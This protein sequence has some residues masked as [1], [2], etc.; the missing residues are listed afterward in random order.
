MVRRVKGKGKVLFEVIY[1]HRR[2]RACQVAGCQVWIIEVEASDEDLFVFMDRENRSRKNPSAFELGDS[3]RRALEARLFPSLNVLSQKL[4][5]DLGNASKA[6]KIATL[7]ADVLAA[8]PRLTEI[9]YRWSKPLSDALQSDP[10]AV[11]A[12]ARRIT[13]E[14]R[15]LSAAQV[16]EQLIG[17]LKGTPTSLE[18]RKAGVD[19]PVALI[20]RADNGSVT[21]KISAGCVAP[22]RLANLQKLI[23][24]FLATKP[25]RMRSGAGG[26]YRTTPFFFVQ[27]SSDTADLPGMRTVGL[28]NEELSPM[29]GARVE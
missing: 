18:V 22:D 24:G 14:G 11:L 12:M 13:G 28:V 20:A 15:D 8:F 9:Q 7:P 23:E 5:V 2:L 16:Y 29:E 17:K 26:L 27:D 6:Y 10:D 4:G 19:K 3:Y 1:G 21:V 25:S